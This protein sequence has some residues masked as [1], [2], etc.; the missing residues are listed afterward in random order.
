MA[1]AMDSKSI[2]EGVGFDLVLLVVQTD[3]IS[4]EGD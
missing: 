3:Y 4:T 1:D 2:V